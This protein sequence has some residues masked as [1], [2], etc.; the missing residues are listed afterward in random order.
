MILFWKHD[1]LIVGILPHC[2]LR[3]EFY[4]NFWSQEKFYPIHNTQRG[5]YSDKQTQI[6]QMFFK[7]GGKKKKNPQSEHFL[8]QLEP[9]LNLG[10]DADFQLKWLFSH[11]C[12]HLLSKI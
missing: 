6:L 5:F 11:K 4:Q 10:V 3:K 12:N 1:T 9:T 2:G 8:A 7:L